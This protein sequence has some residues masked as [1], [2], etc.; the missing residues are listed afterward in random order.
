MQLSTEALRDAGLT[1]GEI[2]VYLAL[3]ELGTSTT[4]SIIERSGVARSIIH[5]LLNKLAQKGLVSYITKEKTKHY[6]ASDP[7]R[8][9]DYIDEREK[10]LQENRAKVQSLLPQLHLHMNSTRP[11]EAK[12]FEG[13]KGAATVHEDMLNRLSKNEE[14]F[15]MGIPANQPEHF[16][17]Y[18]QK[19]HA[20]RHKRGVRI[21]L[22][23]HKDTPE[24]VVR[25]PSPYPGCEG[26]YMPVDIDTPAWFAGCRGVAVVGFPSKNPLT[27]QIINDEI[28]DSFRAY[29]DEFWRQSRKITKK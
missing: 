8:L 5:Q 24:H 13:F 22:L 26:R 17:A 4:G 15:Y 29:F 2:K 20:T 6:Q 10:I 27:I 16:N 12:I 28:A 9:L 7:Q 21:K 14:F 18:W 19:S 1:D 11:S 3:L 25:H 23:F